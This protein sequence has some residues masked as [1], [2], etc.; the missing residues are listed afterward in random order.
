M[1]EAKTDYDAI[2]IGAGFS[3]LGMLYHIREIGL[4]SRVFEAGGGVGG[5]WYWNR[6]PGCRTDSEFYYYC[7]SFSKEVREEWSWKERYPAQPEVLA[8]LEFVASRLD[9]NKDITFNT[10]VTRAEYDEAANIWT[11]TTSDGKSHT[12]RYVVSGMGVLSAPKKPDFPGLD[13]FKGELYQSSSWPAEGVDLKG[14]RVGLIGVGASGVQIVPEIAPVVDEL[15]VFQRTPN[16]VVAST[17][18]P[19]DEEWTK[20]VRENFDETF[21]EARGHG[22]AVPFFK[23]EHGAKEVSAEEREKV[24]EDGW[25]V[26]GFHFMLECFNDLA[27]DEESNRYASEFIRKKIRETVKDPKKAEL[28]APSD[29]PFNGKRPPGGHGYYEAYN[30][31]NVHIVDVKSQPIDEVTPA[32]VKVGGKE[33][34]VDV[35]ICATGFDAMTG[36]LTRIDIV[37]RDGVLLRD[38]WASE[39]LK[40]N[41]G[42]AT[43]GFPNFFMILG[44]TTPYANLPVGIQE[45]VQWIAKAIDFARENNIACLESTKEAEEAWNKEVQEAG[46]QTIM[47]QGGGA[48]AW[49]LGANIPGKPAEFNVYMGGA[50]IYFR[51]CNEVAAGGFKSLCAQAGD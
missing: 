46:S 31:D 26:G 8:Y 13:T 34:E 21:E 17:N 25:T 49:F 4:T 45:G 40:T 18:L 48:K 29:Y 37:G 5:A 33:Y 30:R 10:K 35:L 32:G 6:Y 23:P 14:K 7:F 47:A 16:Y 36:T 28:L 9:L 27:V 39:G 2:I 24:F 15:Y 1:A 12:A 42:M 38:K 3:G 20:R 11:V 44:P 19:V 51:K 50:D 43:N 41:L 22:F